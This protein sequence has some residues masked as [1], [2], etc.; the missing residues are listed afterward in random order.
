MDMPDPYEGDLA[1]ISNWI[2][3]MEV[4]FQV[5]DMD[6][7]GNMILMM[8]QRI[9]KGK[10]NQAGTCSAVKLK[11]W[12]DAKREFTRWVSEGTMSRTASYQERADG[13]S[14]AGVMIYPPLSLKPPYMSW[15]DFT[16]K[17]QEF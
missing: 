6:D 16:T 14:A 5:V 11:E 1:E 9:R 13:V 8:L 10:G 15:G 4:Y 2:R 12:I 3:S 7:M 17:L